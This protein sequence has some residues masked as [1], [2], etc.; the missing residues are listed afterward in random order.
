MLQETKYMKNIVVKK[1][2]AMLAFNE[3]KKD[4]KYNPDKK[5]FV[6]Y[7]DGTKGRFYFDIFEV[8]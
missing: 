6:S 4:I 5:Y 7:I 2:N 3:F 8:I 1:R